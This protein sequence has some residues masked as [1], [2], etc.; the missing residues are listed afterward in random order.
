MLVGEEAV[1]E[2]IFDDLAHVKIVVGRVGEEMSLPLSILKVLPSEKKEKE[3]RETMLLVL[4]GNCIHSLSLSLTF[5]L[6]PSPSLS[7]SLSLHLSE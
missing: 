1:V 7:L 3:V 6:S 4:P 5:A 2:E